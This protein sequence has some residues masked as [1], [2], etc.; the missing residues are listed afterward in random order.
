MKKKSIPKKNYFIYIG[1]C[2]VTVL[3]CF[4]L[5]SWYRI[6]RDYNKN[7]SVMTK[8]ISE[9]NTDSLSNVILEN[10]NVLIYISSASDSDIKSFE[11]QLKKYLVNQELTDSF[12]YM[13]VSKKENENLSSLLVKNYLSI[14]VNLKKIVSPNIIMFKDGKIYNILYLNKSDIS[15]VDVQK[16][17]ERNGVIA[18]D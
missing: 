10:P 12:V 14:D 5:A 16:F 17:L 1:L 13:D 2:I 15:K 18:N 11:K 9:I 8:V 4:Y 3:L 7:N 6:V